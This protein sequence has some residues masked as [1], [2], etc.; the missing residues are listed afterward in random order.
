MG[1]SYTGE[2]M[3]WVK[4][5]ARGMMHDDGGGVVVVTVYNL[6]AIFH[7]LHISSLQCHDVLRTCRTGTPAKGELTSFRV[8]DRQC[9]SFPLFW[10]AHH[11][12]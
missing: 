1:H 12:S 9:R 10:F 2:S 5:V 11:N 7:L 8:W 4:K 3:M 6:I